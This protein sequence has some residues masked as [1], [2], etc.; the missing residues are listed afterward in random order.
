MTRGWLGVAI[1]GI[2]PAIAKSLGLNPDQPNGALV[3]SVTPNSPA[4]KA[5]VKQG[6][7]I[8]AAGGHP[9][10]QVGDLPRIV[11]ADAARAAARSDDPARRQGNDVR[12]TLGELSESPKQA[13]A[14]TPD[15]DRIRRPRAAARRR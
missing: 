11:A 9:V 5:G 2:T 8:T 3:A 12:R 15:E 6:D 1:Q 13:A 10:K 7:V 4:A 14:A